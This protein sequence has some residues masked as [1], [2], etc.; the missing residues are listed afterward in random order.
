MDL[1]IIIIRKNFLHIFKIFFQ[2]SLAETIAINCHELWAKK[3][4]MELENVGAAHHHLL[5]PY[6]LMTD[7]EKQKD[8]QFGQ[9]FLKFLQMN[10]YRIQRYKSLK[11]Y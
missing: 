1:C 7:R 5:V 11:L 10:G 8:I 2:K 4:K 9:E 6:D 3:K